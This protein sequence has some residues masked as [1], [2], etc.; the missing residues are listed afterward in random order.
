MRQLLN[1]CESGDT[2]KVTIDF[3]KYILLDAAHRAGKNID[4]IVIKN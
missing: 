3:H 1:I 4:V 2:I